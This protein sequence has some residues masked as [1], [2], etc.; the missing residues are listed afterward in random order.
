MA[1]NLFQSEEVQNFVS[2]ILENFN[3]SPKTSKKFLPS[4]RTIKRHLK[5]DSEY[6][7]R[8]IRLHGILLANNGTLSISI[9]H[10]C[11]TG[12]TGDGAKMGNGFTISSV[13]TLL[14]KKT[15]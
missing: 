2:A 7:M 11:V 3:E 15:I 1:F 4:A 13:F 12:K 10:K 5:S 8:I 14:R 9:D 6:I